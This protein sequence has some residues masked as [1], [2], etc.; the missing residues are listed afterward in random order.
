MPNVLVFTALVPKLL[1]A[2]VFLDVHDLMPAN[3]MAKFAVGSDDFMVKVLVT[4]QRVSALLADHVLCADHMQEQYLHTVCKIPSGKLMVV[5]NLPNERVFQRTERGP[6]DG[7][8]RLVYHG[9]IA[10][11][12]G[13]DIML[14]AVSIAAE[15]VPVHL[16]IF[17]E[18]DFLPEALEVA[19]Q[20]HLE[21]KVYFSRAFFPVEMISKMV[22]GM[23][24][25]IV[26]NR[27]MLACDKFMLPVKLLEYVYLGIPV[28]A[29][30][31]EI[32]KRYFD[33]SM[34]KYYEPEDVDDFSRCII[35]LYRH[36]EERT[37]LSMKALTFYNEHNWSGQAAAYF[38][39]LQRH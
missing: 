28:I 35:D 4:E 36:P 24:V 7:T 31:L 21:G 10:R 18:G 20:L 6:S 25:G 17:G 26:G 16:S 39:L 5:L 12:L 33:E 15:D 1:G 27:R 11:R 19:Q 13:I 29:P 34:I 22:G 2:K 32:I 8:L 23:D 3:Y 37:R 38:D 9:T 14:R 30:R